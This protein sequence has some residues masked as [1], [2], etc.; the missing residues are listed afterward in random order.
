MKVYI[1]K[2]LLNGFWNL[3]K[4]LRNGLKISTSGRKTI[5]ATPIS[6]EG[7]TLNKLKVAKKIPLR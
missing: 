7:R 4:L 1:D 6:F 5:D 3:L 2:G